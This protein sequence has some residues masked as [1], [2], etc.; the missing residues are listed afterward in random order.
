VLSRSSVNTFQAKGHCEAKGLSNP[1]NG[2]C[3]VA[4]LLAATGACLTAV[5]ASAQETVIPPGVIASGVIGGIEGRTLVTESPAEVTTVDGGVRAKLDLARRGPLH[6]A[7]VASFLSWSYGAGWNENS[8]MANPGLTAEY[9]VARHTLIHVSIG[10]VH[11]VDGAELSRWYFDDPTAPRLG[12]VV[13]GHLFES[14]NVGVGTPANRP[15]RFST[16]IAVILDG[17]IVPDHS[18]AGGAPVALV[19][20][21]SWT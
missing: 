19:F 10:I 17:G 8:Y 1:S 2:G 6:L 16:D 3:F 18:W 14:L 15:V 20:A 7:L 5:R 9:R 11:S 13:R 4:L 21:V 12:D